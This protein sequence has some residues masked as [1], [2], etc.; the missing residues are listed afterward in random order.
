[1]KYI[2]QAN[3]YVDISMTDEDFSLLEKAAEQH[4]D[5]TVRSTIQRGGYLY[6]Q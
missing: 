6:G 3:L 2:F 1:M 5:E 4:Y